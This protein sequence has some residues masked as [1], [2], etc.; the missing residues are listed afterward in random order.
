MILAGLPAT[1]ALAGTTRMRVA[2]KYNAAP[3]SCE[4]FSYGEV[5]DYTVNIGGTPIGRPEI[6]NQLGNESAIFDLTLYPNP[7]DSELN[8]AT[9]D[10]RVV[11]YRIV[12]Y[13]GQEVRNGKF[14]N[15]ENINVRDL[16]NGI[17][18]VEINDGQKSV[19]KKFIK[20]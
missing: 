19:I 3:T 9:I 12:N 18:I 4:T 20:K 10:G 5:E 2:M 14:S 16:T 17:Y 7:T 1:T 13:L 6:G 15:K 11:S 8:I